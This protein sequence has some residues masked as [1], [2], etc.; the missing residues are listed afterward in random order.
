[1]AAA[2]TVALRVRPT[3]GPHP[4]REGRLVFQLVSPLCDTKRAHSSP[5][6]KWRCS[7]LDHRCIWKCKFGQD[8]R[9]RQHTGTPWR[10]PTSCSGA[11]R[12]K[13]APF[14]KTFKASTL[15]EKT[16]PSAYGHTKKRVCT[17]QCTSALHQTKYNSFLL[18]T[19]TAKCLWPVTC[20]SLINTLSIGN[21]IIAPSKTLLILH[22]GFRNC[23]KRSPKQHLKPQICDSQC[24]CYNNRPLETLFS[25]CTGIMLLYI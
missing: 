25:S 22:V 17:T 6:Y 3:S 2:E 20:C 13:A 5:Q 8:W 15:Q 1:M 18:M 19:A 11:D 7:A 24:S 12:S 14:G 23:W 9:I 21:K 4:R 10:A 16:T